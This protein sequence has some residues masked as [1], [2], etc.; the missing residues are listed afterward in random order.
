MSNPGVI[1]LAKTVIDGQNFVVED[2][3]G[4]SI[5]IHYGHIRLDMSIMEFLRLA[6]DF[7][8][9]MQALVDVDGL[10]L[11][12]LDPLFLHENARIFTKIESVEVKD[13][14][15]ADLMVDV[16]FLSCFF[17]FRP[18]K[19]SRVVRALHGNTKEN[20]EH[21]QINLLWQTNEERLESVKKALS[22]HSYPFDG[23]Y[24]V[25]YNGQPYIKDGQHRASCLVTDNPQIVTQVMDIRFKN[26]LY[27]ISNWIRFKMVIYSLWMAFKNLLRRI[28]NV[29]LSKYIALRFKL[30]SFW[31]RLKGR[32]QQ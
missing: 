24:I 7:M 1:M 26:N 31:M 8:D 12:K 16:L 32:K 21:N 11:R 20:N 2:N 14:K 25:I 17:V 4:E 3:I 28:Y 29:K 30:L 19:Y 15:L 27:R 22:I 23:R 6:D 10:C 9:A 13:M 5:H 18:L